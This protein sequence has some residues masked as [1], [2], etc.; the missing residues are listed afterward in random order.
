MRH[1]RRAN[2]RQQKEGVGEK[3]LDGED[4]GHERRAK[5]G[6]ARPDER[7]GQERERDQDERGPDPV[8]ADRVAPQEKDGMKAEES[9]R[10]QRDAA[11]RRKGLEPDRAEEEH[12]HAEAEEPQGG[13]A[14]PER[15]GISAQEEQEEE[16]KALVGKPAHDLGPVDRRQ[17]ERK[18]ATCTASAAAVISAPAI[19]S[20]PERRRNPRSAVEIAG[21]GP[22]PS[23][24]VSRVVERGR[25]QPTI[26]IPRVLVPFGEI[27]SLSS[28][29]RPPDSATRSTRPRAPPGRLK[30]VRRRRGLRRGTSA[31]RSSSRACSSRARAAR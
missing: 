11:L 6:L 24:E 20:R 1:D 14:G 5:D 25:Y 30:E 26:A 3:E 21:A 23:G 28:P 18:R 4:G 2:E 29:R 8:A 22:E 13:I 16:R 27:P 12:S 31:R 19:H 17:A 7:A 15:R 10:D 9:E